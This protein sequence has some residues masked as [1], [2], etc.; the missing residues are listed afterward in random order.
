[1]QAK[2]TKTSAI[3]VECNPCSLQILGNH[4][5]PGKNR[6]LGIP[7]QTINHLLCVL[8]TLNFCLF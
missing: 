5:F 4:E 3:S 2:G 8:K 7:Y 6:L 1:M